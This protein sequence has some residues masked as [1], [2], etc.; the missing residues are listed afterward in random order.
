M[1]TITTS[2]ARQNF[3]DLLSSVAY[4]KERIA[5]E[6]RGRP[7]AVLLPIEELEALEA[8]GKRAPDESG[9]LL[10]ALMEGSPVELAVKDR[11]GRYLMVSREFERLNGKTGDE[12][13]GRSPEDMYPPETAEAIQRHDEEVLKTGKTVEWEIDA[14]L[15]DGIHTYLVAKFPVRGADNRITGI[16]GVATDITEQKKAQAALRRS[17]E[18]LKA[19]MD[20]AP[21]EIYLKDTEGRYL[22]INRRYETLWGITNEGA[23]SKLPRD[24]HEQKEFAESA[25]QHDL[26]VLESGET[27][28]LEQEV[29]LDE[30]LH[31]LHMTK[32]PIRDAEG[33]ISGLGAIASDVTERKRTEERLRESE[34]RYRDIVENVGDLIQ[35]IGPDGRYLFVNESWR[36]ILGY[37]E[38]DLKSLT[39]SDVVHEDFRPHCRDIFERLGR[40]ETFENV[41]VVF[42]AKDGRDVVTEGHLGSVIENGQ[43]THTRAIFRDITERKRAEEA[44]RRSHDELELRVLER[45]RDIEEANATLRLEIAERKRAEEAL[46]ESEARANAAEVQLRDAIESISDGFI[47]F[48]ADERFILCNSKYRE[49]IPQIAELLVPGAKLENLVRAASECGAITDNA[50]EIEDWT[51]LRIENYRKAHGTHELHLQDGRWFLCSERKTQAGGVVGVRTNITERKLAEAALRESEERFRDFAEAASDWFWAMDKNLRFTYFSDRFLE[52]TGR[53][54][55]HL[56]GLTRI[57]GA[58]GDPKEDHWRK[59][60]A[61]LDARRLFRDFR[62]QLTDPDGRTRYRSI[63]GKPIF[64]EKGTFK[65]YR[66]T[67]NDVTLQV[68]AE[69]ALRK[70]EAYLRAL[71]EAN[72]SSIFLKD[73]D[74]R[75]V[76]INSAFEEL[77]SAS[78]DEII[79][80]TLE[81]LNLFDEEYIEEIAAFDDEVLRTGKVI[82]RE[83]HPALPDGRTP[84]T[85]L[86][87]F[88]IIGSDGRPTGIGAMETDVTE[89]KEAEN[90]L[91]ES[92]ARF[93]AIIDNSPATISLKDLDGRY[94]LI[95]RTYLE[96]IG[97]SAEEVQ[98]LVPGDFLTKELAQSI[99]ADTS[100]VLESGET[101]VTEELMPLEDGLHTFLSIKFPIRDDSGNLMGIGSIAT[102]I[103]EQKRAEE[104]IRTRDA[105]LRAIFEN[106]PIEIVLKNTDGRFMAVSRN[107]AE[108][109]GVEM[110]DLIGGTTADFLP[111]HI[112]DIYMAADRKV[113][114][115]GQPIQQEVVEEL[116]GSTRHSLSAKFPLKDDSGR[117]TGICS[118]TSDITEVKQAEERL[119]H[120]Q[121]LEAVGQLTGGVAHDFN[122]LLAII[123][124]NIELLADV[125]GENDRRVQTVF[126]AAS[127]GAELTQR[128]LAFS[129]R[130]PLHPQAIELDELVE[131]VTHLLFR[132]LGETIEV[133]VASSAD[134]WLALADPGQ[135]ENALLNLAIN[136]RDAMVEGGRLV[137]ETANV[138]IDARGS[139]DEEEIS[140][141]DYVMLA[142]SDTG[143]GI[144][145]KELGRVFE[146]FFTTKEVG[147]GSG[148]GLSMV[149]GFARQSGGHVTIES[150]V[151]E[152]TT[153]RLYLPRAEARPDLG[154]EKEMGGVQA[155]M[156]E[157]E[158]VLVVEDDPDVRE[159]AAS[160]LQAQDYDVITAP[161]GR[162]AMK[163]LDTLKRIDL[164][165]CD[166]MLPGG[167]SGS[168]IADRALRRLPGLKVLFMSGHPI[169]RR[170][171]EGKDL[172]PMIVKPFRRADLI[173][174][175]QEVL[176]DG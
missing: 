148:L 142:V 129:R 42:K 71:V 90:R 103:T 173:R 154:G 135:V 67:A 60:Q 136:A 56:I 21:V 146:P 78:R 53:D 40:G 88:P 37:D 92:E 22:E 82:H 87:K 23:R 77:L 7:L 164:L 151:G 122:N 137:I 34:E 16:G 61:D 36:R 155:P 141:G 31:I 131:G 105:W 26:D 127:R 68:E 91:Q 27:V 81:E 50:E 174:R 8:G 118:L 66:G 14:P 70:N 106:A 150:Q 59:H 5:I 123:L 47:L 140:A 41:E 153:V 48:D 39:F 46:R 57:E 143:T 24:I 152:G 64:D 175:V 54:R 86:T 74:G 161:D 144:P 49:F 165:L 65:G 120:A 44:L 20:N 29:R 138:T 25:R 75:Y 28:E 1:R 126:H 63:S 76:V 117:I 121:K 111:G 158:I 17:E 43:L 100:A 101:A 32:F 89:H 83:Q 94:L 125:V 80:R 145:A 33:R 124:G 84:T 147:K 107:V 156:A 113:L 97:L 102:D 72:P 96:L 109:L 11:D 3:A 93:R 110:D 172:G 128:L 18:R 115:T 45:T 9:A 19:I 114:E 99:E 134:P 52:A 73:L 15:Q 167:L 159:L 104:T 4:G 119:R 30:E 35:S 112:A 176:R 163:L 12:I 6:R 133:E 132:T 171:D 166:I 69:E 55:N 51:R 13:I 10:K 38:D 108:I 58:A 79:G 2:D 169:S 116:D 130:Q 162:V 160:I 98:G 85:I 168:D 139:N 170:E 157:G 95:N 149:Y 62:Y